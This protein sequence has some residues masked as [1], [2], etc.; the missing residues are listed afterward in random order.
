MD[1]SAE[2][3][4]LPAWAP[5]SDSLFSVSSGSTRPLLGV[6][7]HVGRVGVE[8]AGRWGLLADSLSLVIQPEVARR[9]AEDLIFGARQAESAEQK[10]RRS[11]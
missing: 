1:E 10:I 7:D 4:G 11:E 2:D 3:P 5:A 9:L 8:L 6:Q